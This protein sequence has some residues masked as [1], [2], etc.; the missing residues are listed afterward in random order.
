M[1]KTRR[2]KRGGMRLS[3]ANFAGPHYGYTEGSSSFRVN[4][5]LS[6]DRIAEWLANKLSTLDDIPSIGP[7]DIAKLK[8]VGI[9]DVIQLIG[10]VMIIVGRPL[11]E[12]EEGK[13]G[14]RLFQLTSYLK[15]LGIRYPGYV[16]YVLLLKIRR[17]LGI[18]RNDTSIMFERPELEDF[19]DFS[20][21]PEVKNLV[22]AKDVAKHMK[23]SLKDALAFIKTPGYRRR[24]AL[25][26][27]GAPRDIFSDNA[28]G[29]G[30]ASKAR[31]QTRRRKN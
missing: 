27:W 2:V 17:L 31:R 12:E 20:E 30:A 26:T 18:T 23:M 9:E 16:A 15:E 8:S 7:A 5:G 10:V 24:H 28:A 4:E 19:Y 21:I 29:A 22:N 3:D 14:I 1:D 6:H 25:A 13:P 11:S